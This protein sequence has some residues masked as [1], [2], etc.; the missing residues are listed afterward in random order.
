VAVPVAIVTVTRHGTF[1]GKVSEFIGKA[2]SDPSFYLGLAAVFTPILAASF[3]RFP[4]LYA[5]LVPHRSHG[6]L[7]VRAGDPPIVPPRQ[8]RQHRVPFET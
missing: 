1:G 3:P 2:L 8:V 4:L 5:R 7:P 6:Q